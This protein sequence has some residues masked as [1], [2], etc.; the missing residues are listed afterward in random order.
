MYLSNNDSVSVC[1]LAVQTHA[2]F[3]VVHSSLGRFV[4]TQLAHNTIYF[5]ADRFFLGHSVIPYFIRYSQQL[6]PQSSSD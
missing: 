1:A 6:T 5:Q 4:A 3:T 2:E